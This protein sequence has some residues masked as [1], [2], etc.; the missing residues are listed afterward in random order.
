MADCLRVLVSDLSMPDS[1][2]Q[3]F[4]YHIKGDIEEAMAI[5]RS[6]RPRPAAAQASADTRTEAMVAA[7]TAPASDPNTR[8][9]WLP[10][11][12]WLL[13]TEAAGQRFGPTIEAAVMAAM[14]SAQDSGRRPRALRHIA[15]HWAVQHGSHRH[16]YHPQHTLSDRHHHHQTP[17]GGTGT[18]LQ[19]AECPAWRAVTDW[20]RQAGARAAGH[21]LLFTPPS[22]YMDSD[23]LD[24]CAEKAID[25]AVRRAI[26]RGTFV[27]PPMQADV[28]GQGPDRQH[29]HQS[30]GKRRRQEAGPKAAGATACA[31]TEI[32]WSGPAGLEENLLRLHVAA[33]GPA[34][35]IRTFNVTMDTIL[36]AALDAV[37]DT[38]FDTDPEPD[39]T[40]PP[41][42]PCD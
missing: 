22:P 11:T 21:I 5:I 7:A 38:S 28:F 15:H 10:R 4:H 26:A 8:F 29:R 34:A 19:P 32:H 3:D 17:A 23:E 1:L 16:H 42:P 20:A 33:S 37:L 6:M 35:D 39:P 40:C 36:R 12:D 18:G 25:M 2:R 9:G 13:F 27:E 31:S 30:H 24:Q 41:G 14:A